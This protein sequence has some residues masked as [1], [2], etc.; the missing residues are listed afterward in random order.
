MERKE[1]G[2]LGWKEKVGRGGTRN[3][4]LKPIYFFHFFHSPNLVGNWKEN[5]WVDLNQ[6][7]FIF[8]FD[9][10]SFLERSTFKFR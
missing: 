9:Q 8:N 5:A 6:S 2:I 3:F 10:W 4:S 7:N 1:I